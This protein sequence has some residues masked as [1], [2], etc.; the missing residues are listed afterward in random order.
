MASVECLANRNAMVAPDYQLADANLPERHHLSGTVFVFGAGQLAHER[1]FFSFDDAELVVLYDPFEAPADLPPNT[2]YF[3]DFD[4]ALTHAGKDLDAGLFLFSL[5]LEPQWLF[6]LARVFN[7]IRVEGQLFFAEDKGF[8]SLLDDGPRDETVVESLPTDL[9]GAVERLFRLRRTKR[10]FPWRPDISASDYG[11]AFE[12]LSLFTGDRDIRRALLRRTYDPASEP[13]CYLPW[14]LGSSHG[15]ARDK[16]YGFVDSRSLEELS[17]LLS[18]LRVVTEVIQVSR[19]TKSRP[20]PNLMALDDDQTRAIWNV[21]GAH[22]ARNI[23]A[24]QVPVPENTEDTESNVAAFTENF[25]R[26]AYLNIFRHF[27]TTTSCEIIVGMSRFLAKAATEANLALN[28]R[29]LKPAVFARKR[30]LGVTFKREPWYDAYIKRALDRGSFI[31]TELWNRKE[32][33]IY[34]WPGKRS[35]RWLIDQVPVIQVEKHESLLASYEKN[36]VPPCLYFVESLSEE[37]YAPLGAF[38]AYLDVTQPAGEAAAVIEMCRL[39]MPVLAGRSAYFEYQIMYREQDQLSAKGEAF[40][41]LKHSFDNALNKGIDSDQASKDDIIATWLLQTKFVDGMFA[42][43]GVR[44]DPLVWADSGWL[45]KS[46][47]EVLAMT[48]SDAQLTVR[49]DDAALQ[50]RRVDPRIL[51]LLYELGT[52]ARRR[53]QTDQEVI[54]LHVTV[55]SNTCVS[56]KL[57]IPVSVIDC[58]AIIG[59]LKLPL[60]SQARR[61]GKRM[62]G[63][64]IIRRIVDQLH[65]T[66]AWMFTSTG[67]C[68]APISEVENCGGAVLADTAVREMLCRADQE[69]AV[70]DMAFE[71]RAMIGGIAN[72]PSVQS[73]DS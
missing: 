68:A 10:P 58:R 38:V 71:A 4:E 3:G 57:E 6:Y 22:A 37:T 19:L 60:P 36:E 53:R 29:E 72:V 43:A 44:V 31:A 65:G 73:T 64:R 62:S 35:V 24:A 61:I 25:L 47:G 14:S 20:M 39:L 54:E 5:H 18:G 27:V 69:S 33:A 26:L 16:P 30:T 28:I 50:S 23:A 49:V 59:R 40:Q 7:R 1:L 63:V 17:D 41:A 32:A 66:A 13:A 2:V 48:L 46:F 51:V 42:Y 70:I 45:G 21:M 11:L 12:V 52:N 34:Y 56:I 9:I 67:E 55:E 15:G 8:R